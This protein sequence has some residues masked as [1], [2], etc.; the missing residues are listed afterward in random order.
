[1]SFAPSPS[2]HQF[3]SWCV[4]QPFPVMG[5]LWHC[6]TH[7]MTFILTRAGGSANI[8]VIHHFREPGFCLMHLRGLA[9]VVGRCPVSH[10]L[11]VQLKRIRKWK[12]KSMKTLAKYQIYTM[13]I[14]YKLQ[15]SIRLKWQNFGMNIPLIC[16]LLLRHLHIGFWHVRLFNAGRRSSES[17]SLSNCLG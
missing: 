7:I 1:M 16:G 6:Y 5:G 9:D 4:N 2:H 17:A 15:D 13:P 8:K 11:S 14:K 3:D 12:W 10:G